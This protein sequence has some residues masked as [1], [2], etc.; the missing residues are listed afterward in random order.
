M[1][2]RLSGRDA[3]TRHRLLALVVYGLVC[4]VFGAVLSLIPSPSGAGEFWVGNFAAPWLVL[5]FVGG[6]LLCHR[7]WAPAVGAVCDTACVVGFYGHFLFVDEHRIRGRGSA[8]ASRVADNLAH[9]LVFIAP[10]VAVALVAG[11]AFGWLGGRWARSRST[12]AGVMLA[13][14]FLVEPWV[15]SLGL[16]YNR[17]SWLPWAAETCIGLVILAWVTVIRRQR[18]TAPGQAAG[19]YE[20]KT[21]S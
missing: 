18:R 5:A 15:W 13:V 9:W 3:L 4:G 21:V 8:I 1:N 7:F 14:P 10:W 19:K 6:W 11:T 20:R 16:G 2:A 17:G 12:L